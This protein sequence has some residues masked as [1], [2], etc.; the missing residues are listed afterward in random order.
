MS[1]LVSVII[2]T[3]RREAE[4]TSALKSL[5]GQTYKNFEII[6]VDDNADATWNLKVK[7]AVE[8]F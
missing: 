3:Y 8:E 5:V 2:A 7:N 6:V 4:L 1:E